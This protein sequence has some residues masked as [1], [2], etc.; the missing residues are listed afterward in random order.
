[1]LG[2]SSQTPDC[3]LRNADAKSQSSA[4]LI[5]FHAAPSPDIDGINFAEYS[6]MNPSSNPST[7]GKPAPS[8]ASRKGAGVFL[9]IIGAILCFTIVIPYVGLFTATIGAVLLF[10]GFGFFAFGSKG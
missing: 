9:I 5:C 10:C 1:V 7:E 4:R 6:L 3:F 2:R 8:R